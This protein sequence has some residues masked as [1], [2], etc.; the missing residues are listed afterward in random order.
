MNRD[1]GVY[2]ITSPSG[3]QYVGSSISFARRWAIHRRELR[4]G[5]HHCKPLQFA[6]D[7][8]GMDALV[9]D[10]IVCC[11]IPELI[12]I[13]Q[14]EIDRRLSAGVGLYNTAL[15][16]GSQQGL[17]RSVESREK[18]AAA[19]RG[20]PVP[21]SAR[22]KLSKFHQGNKYC[23]GKVRPPEIR[24]KISRSLSGKSKSPEHAKNAARAQI[25]RRHTEGSL[26]KMR[27]AKI[28][29]TLN[30]EHRAK[31]GTAN[32]GKAS[33][34]NTSG[35]PGVVFCKQTG[36]WRGM[37]G[38]DRKSYCCGRHATAAE[39]YAAILA[40]RLEIEGG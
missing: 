23:L 34:R 16:A 33:G 19:R 35:Y 4:R 14:R 38:I 15:V 13:E 20:K 32:R 29:K 8:Y 17:R 3:K 36:R 21:A 12:L 9:F 25:G 39:A 18:M 6:A 24:T 7:K 37:F 40:K 2:A 28:G 30:A 27:A 10:R 11:A 22:E 26:I 31:I 1:T 5:T